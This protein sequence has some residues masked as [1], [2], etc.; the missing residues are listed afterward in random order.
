MKMALHS[1]RD[2]Q[3][4]STVAWQI[5]DLECAVRCALGTGRADNLSGMQGLMN[6][7][8]NPSRDSG[9]QKQFLRP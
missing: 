7:A 8:L 1:P 6:D 3:V 2:G 4:S 9:P 5:V